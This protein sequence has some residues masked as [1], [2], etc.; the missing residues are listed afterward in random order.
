M[1]D[2]KHL[3]PYELRGELGRGAMARVWRAWDPKL[4]REVAIK[5]PLFD[6]RL[7]DDVLE[8]MGE[9]FVKEGRAAARLNHPGIVTI[10]AT[11]IYDRHPAIVMELIDGVTLGKMLESRPLSP[12]A[13]LDVLDQLL[14]AVGYAHSQ[15]IVHRDIKPDNIFVTKDGRIKLADF[16]IAHIEDSSLTKKT[17]VGTILGTPGYMAPEQATG[18][19]VDNRT[20]L[21]SIGTIAYEMLT[22]KNPFGAGEGTD[23]TTLI[24]RIVHEPTPE[25]PDFTTESLPTD[26][27]PAILATLNKN[28]C[29]RPQDAAAFKA[30]LHGAPAPAPGALP[31]ASPTQTRPST[32]GKSSKKWLPYA[33][34]GLVGIMVL[35]LVFVF[36]M[37]NSGG[38]VVDANPVQTMDTSTTNTEETD[39]DTVY[40]IDV[41]GKIAV[42][43]E[44][45]GGTSELDR[46][47][48]IATSYLQ[49]EA[50][51]LLKEGILVKDMIT[52]EALLDTYRKEAESKVAAEKEEAESKVAA[53]K[54]TAESEAAAEKGA[55]RLT[56]SFWG[57]WV[58]AS[59]SESEAQT[60]VAEM[61]AKGASGGMVLTTDW[62]N[63]NTDP[64]YVVY[65]GERFTDQAIA[66]NAVHSAV[67]FGYSSAY[68]KYTGGY[69]R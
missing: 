30:M 1:T 23:S 38:G 37:S 26:I 57:V 65:F 15:G 49:P 29:E 6:E 28:P 25:L 7:S 33:L 10:Y 2:G 43:H 11:D 55:I 21:F 54:A 50:V 52:A 47:T 9:R 22:G 56:D 34:V 42:Y 67:A 5:E 31:V 17:Q 44:T 32:Q 20:D 62:S 48:D 14:D 69:Q 51:K 46:I 39:K 40:L 53:E 45:P 36:A 12:K 3:G 18:S 66:E 68:V 19:A 59:Q 58:F 41:G 8:E 27:R 61:Q 60:V 13:A 24:Y 16:G 63:L 35:G 4:E 64:W